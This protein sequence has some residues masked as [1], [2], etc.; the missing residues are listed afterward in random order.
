EIGISGSTVSYGGTAIGS[1]SGGVGVSPLVVC[2]NS[3]ATPAAV[4]ALVRNLTYR[5]VGS[6]TATTTRTVSVKVAHADTGNS[7]ANETIR[8]GLLRYADFQPGLDH[9]YGIYTNE[10]DCHL[11]ENA[12]STPFPAG[13][14]GGLFIDW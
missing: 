10:S 7:I 5:N 12:P 2:L 9:G 6:S 1:I 8:V 4:Q 3:S 11:R 13:S 14:G